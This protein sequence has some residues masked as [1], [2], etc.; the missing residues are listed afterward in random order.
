MRNL[1]SDI[2]EALDLKTVMEDNGVVFNSR[3]FAACPFHNEK[4]PSLSVKN[5]RF[6]CFGCGASGSVIDFIRQM[7]NLD[8]KQAVVRLDSQYHLGLIGRKPTYRERIQERE[9]RRMNAAKKAFD[10]KL[11]KNHS[12]L[13][14]VRR[15]L[16]GVYVAEGCVNEYLKA[17]I[18]YL[19]DILDDFTG[20]KARK[21]W[22]INQ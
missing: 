17:Y 7:Y 10:A 6:K 16:F 22:L 9:I 21:I 5:G 4:E 3:G 12:A 20:N 14:D 8:F 13:T 2:C 15:R 11:I 19:D 18:D 1:A